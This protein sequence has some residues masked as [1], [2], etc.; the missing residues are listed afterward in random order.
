[1]PKLN[2]FD[3]S[4]RLRTSDYQIFQQVVV[5]LLEWNDVTFA[6]EQWYIHSKTHFTAYI[7]FLLQVWTTIIPKN[8]AIKRLT[9][10]NNL[11]EEQAI[12]RIEAQ[13]SNRFYVK[14]A[15]V[16][17]STLWEVQ[18]TK[19]QVVKAWDLLQKRMWFCEI[20]YYFV[21]VYV[22]TCCFQIYYVMGSESTSLMYIDICKWKKSN[23]KIVTNVCLIWIVHNTFQMIIFSKNLHQAQIHWKNNFGISGQYFMWGNSGSYALSR[24]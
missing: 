1:M 22:N 4:V 23:I 11:S 7:Y 3:N 12:S 17:F 2:L 14:N 10:R 18:Y 16:V 5:T 24:I 19:E 21:C 9:E 20:G 15:H 6:E 13:P 8:E